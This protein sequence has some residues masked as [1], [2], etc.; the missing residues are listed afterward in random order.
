MK[1]IKSLYFQLGLY[2]SKSGWLK[3]G[4][5]SKIKQSKFTNRFETL[6]LPQNLQTWE[7]LWNNVKTIESLALKYSGITILNSWL[8]SDELD[9]K[10]RGNN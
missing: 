6:W 3:Y 1:L 10:C 8:S 2:T 9:T 5:D 7:R 4:V